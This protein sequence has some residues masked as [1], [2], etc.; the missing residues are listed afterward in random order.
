MSSQEMIGQVVGHYRILRPVGQGGMAAAFL[1]ED[2]RLRR[3][4]AVKV[5]RPRPG[6]TGDF[7]RRFA[8][9]AQVLARLDHPNILPVYD[10]GEQDGLAYLIMPYMAG[11]SL[12]ELLHTRRILPPVEALRLLSQ[13]L[14]AL[15]Y[16]HERGLVHRDVKPGNMLFK[17]DGTLV[18]ADF[19]LVKILATDGGHASLLDASSQTGLGI[20]GTPQYMAPEQ[21]RGQASPVSDIYS[22][23]VVLYEMLTGTRP[24]VADNAMAI[25]MKHLHEQPRPLR[26]INPEIPTALEAV[27]LHALEKN[28][29][30]R[31]QRSTDLLQ[32]LI[33]V[34]TPGEAG[35][36]VNSVGEPGRTIPAAPSPSPVEVPA[37]AAMA[38]RT[39]TSDNEGTRSDAATTIPTSFPASEPFSTQPF[40]QRS[41]SHSLLKRMLLVL[42]AFVVLSSSGG[43]LLGY[44]FGWFSPQPSP[45][46]TPAVRSTLKGGGITPTAMTA[47]ISTT[48][49]SC[50]AVGTARA[51]VTAHLTLGGHQN[52]VY[53]VNKGSPV[54]PTSGTLK[55][56][57]LTTQGK[58]DIVQMPNASIDEAQVSED[59][60]WI[61]FI[62]HVNGQ[63]ELRM[64]RMD[65]QGMQTLTCAPPGKHFFNAQWSADQQLLVFDEGGDFG[66][67]TMYV[68]NMSRGTLQPELLPTS[69]GM[70]FWP[71]TWLDN[72]RV[73]VVGF[74]PNS[75]APLRGLY[76]LDTAHGPNQ[77]SA[78]LQQT[79]KVAGSCWDFDSSTDGTE[80]FVS[81]CM[82]GQHGSGSVRLFTPDG[83]TP[84]T[85]LNSTRLAI[86]RVRSTDSGL[87]LSVSNMA[88]GQTNGDMSQDGLWK[89][90]LDGSGLTRLTTDGPGET[91]DLNPFTQDPWSNVSRDGKMYAFTL[92]NNTTG[93]DTLLVSSLSGGKPTAFASIGGTQL[94]I[95]G[96]T[97]M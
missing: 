35:N 41:R 80:L 63:V 38:S 5:F 68:L 24:F 21:V 40:P 91:S 56:Y 50:P 78:S 88:L 4:V 10:Y 46:P 51:A 77:Q 3:E 62:A 60:Q 58:T 13:I 54:A 90:S 49:T 57:D 61:L 45:T 8:R 25:W 89:T 85:I 39:S 55:R 33:Q 79:L 93:T 70:G 29:A 18:L 23:G 27:V 11:G 94:A 31:Y 69:Q 48:L 53:I 71:R 15:H 59:G 14:Q 81:Q 44:A 7:L 74:V 19:G 75:D 43:A 96:W 64:V 72:T 16:A 84:T 67:P 32:A 12:K 9:E 87:L 86:A 36:T 52:I 73:Y 1:A 82:Q 28:P 92:T 66:A 42:L 76:I 26:E 20:S 6:E 30:K 97:T 34:I 65:G 83:G 37:S 17:A 2:I 22:V 47:P 95:A